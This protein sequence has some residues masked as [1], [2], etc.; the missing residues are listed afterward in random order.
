MSRF[1]AAYRTYMA[2]AT[3]AP[4]SFVMAGGLACLSTISLS[5][6]WLNKGNGVRP[7]VFLMLTADSSKNRKSFSVDTPVE[8]LRDVEEDR[9][10]PKD[11]TS[12][13]LIFTMRKRAKGKSRNKLVL[14]ISEFGRYLAAAQSYAA[15]TGAMLCD[16]YDGDDYERVRSGKRPLYVEKP[17]LSMLAAVAYG[18][19]EKY[20]DPKDWI[21]GFFARIVWVMPEV[22]PDRVRY[23]N[24]PTKPTAERDLAKAALIDLREELKGSPGA[25]AVSA[26]ADAMFDAFARPFASQE[27]NDPVLEAQRERLLNTIWKFATLFQID[28]NPQHAIGPQAMQEAI[29]FAL[30]AWDSFQKIYAKTAASPFVKLANRVHRIVWDAGGQMPSREVYR[31]LH[32][33][34]EHL[35]RVLDM[36]VKMGVL[37]VVGSGRSVVVKAL[38]E[39]APTV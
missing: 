24:Q 12:E 39:P 35:T 36:L 13:G 15:S 33:S 4:K 10:G 1:L 6:R 19:L 5:R 3:D 38:I 14:P 34:S 27:V 7:N 2:K 32:L 22:D 31:S 37:E 9:V 30:Q 21:T 26:P 20:A 29:T 11:F 23:F 17:R 28:E 25:M 18:M 16:L 8:L